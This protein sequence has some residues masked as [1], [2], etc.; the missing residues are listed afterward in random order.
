MWVFD[1]TPLVYLAQVDRL[2]SITALDSECFIP[3]RVYEEVV[4]TGIEHGYPDARRIEQCVDDGLFD[5]VTVDE[6][7]AYAK[8]SR[9]PN[10]SDAD[11]AVLV[12]ADELNG[13]AI[14]DER[15][16][17]EVAATERISSRGTAYVL[18]SLIKEGILTTDEVQ[19][20]IDAMIDAGWYC[21]PS[22]YATIV[23][24]LRAL[25]NEE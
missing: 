22:L 1:A 13:T 14:M 18:L 9:N 3:K 4:T 24:K 2:E 12:L 7:A 25:S 6:T 20:T 10:L 15:Y 5:V 11:I 8:L 17:R 16:G 23:Q 21:S 19:S